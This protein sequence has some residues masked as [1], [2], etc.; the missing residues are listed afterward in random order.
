MTPVKAPGVEGGSCH[1]ALAWS[2]LAPQSGSAGGDRSS[3]VLR[4]TLVLHHPRRN[5][6]RLSQHNFKSSSRLV[7]PERT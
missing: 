2:S 5:R 7:L 3:S 4:P 6:V 1:R